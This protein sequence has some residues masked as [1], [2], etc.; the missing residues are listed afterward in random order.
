MD[1]FWD[2]LRNHRIIA[3][4]LCMIAVAVVLFVAL[5]I[6][7]SS[8]TRHNDLTVLP[9]VKYLQVEEAAE[10]LGRHNLR[11]EIIDSIFNEKAT[12]GMVVEQTPAAETKIKEERIVYLTIN[13]Y[14][15]EAVKVPAIINTSLRQAEA[16]LK[17]V[18]IRNIHIEHLPS[19]Y[20]GLVLDVKCEGRTI[21][22]GEKVATSSTITL[23][24]GSGFDEPNDSVATEEIVTDEEFLIF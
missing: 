2:F 21:E 15:P 12:P 16:Q 1:K 17:S 8:Y 23:V 4:L 24:V 20:K 18:G 14:S 19:P 11:Y 22:E 3:H 5:N 6:W 7:L 9:S 10:V 13:A